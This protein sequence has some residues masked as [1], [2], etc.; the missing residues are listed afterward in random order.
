MMNKTT[1]F[2]MMNK[3]TRR[4]T[5]FSPGATWQLRLW[6]GFLWLVSV[7]LWGQ[8]L[9]KDGDW[10]YLENTKPNDALKMD[11]TIDG[12]SIDPEHNCRLAIWKQGSVVIPHSS[13]IQ[14][15]TVF[16]QQ[17]TTGKSQQITTQ[18]YFTNQG[19]RL[20][21]PSMLH[22][23]YLDNKIR[24]LKLQKGYMMTV[25]TEGDGMGYSR[26]FVAD[27]ADLVLDTL[28]QLLDSKISYIRVLPW[29]YVSKKGWAGSKWTSVPEGLKY[30][31][32][33]SDATNST[34]YYNWSTT[35][36]WTTNPNRK[37]KS[38]NQEFVPE[39]WGTGSI[40]SPLYSLD[41]VTHLMGYNEPDHG[42]Q[43][44]VS[45][46]DAIAEWP[47][48]MQTGLRL[49]SP[50]TTDFN[51][52]YSFMREAKS[53][54]YRVDYVVVHAYWGGLSGAEWYQ[55]LKEVHDA[56]GRP[57]W[58]KEWNNGANWTKEGWPSGTA[59]QQAKQLR[60]LQQILTVMDTCSFIERYSIYNWVEDKRAV[61]L[62]TG[63]LTPAG[64]Y[65]R[66]NNPDY[67]Y[68]HDQQF[69]PTYTVRTA[70]VLSFDQIKDGVALIS[71]TDECAEMIESYRLETSSDG[72]TFT[73][74]ANLAS[75]TASA[76][77]Q[78]EQMTSSQIYIRVTSVPVSGN[79]QNSNVL[80]LSVLAN[81][82][83]S[84]VQCHRMEVQQQ[85]SPVLWNRPF[86]ET[87]VIIASPTTYRNK[88]PLAQRLRDV[89]GAS[90]SLA[91]RTWKYQQSPTLAYN[92]T[93]D[94][95][96]V[97]SGRSDW[98]GIDVE[99]GRCLSVTSAMQ[100]VSFTRPFAEVPVVIPTQ[101]SDHQISASSVRALNITTEGFDV[102]LQYE[103][104]TR[105]DTL[106]EEVCWIAATPGVG[107]VD[108]M[109]VAVGRS[110][111]P[112]EDN[113]LGGTPVAYGQQFSSLPYYYAAMQTEIDTIT[114]NLR[115]K[116]RGLECATL[117]K[118][119]E[120]SVA[121]ERVKGEQVGYIAIGNQVV[122]SIPFLPQTPR[123]TDLYDLSGRPV[124]QG[125]RDKIVVRGDGKKI[126]K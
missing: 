2:G 87:P 105:N 66:D 51:W 99:A 59:E 29:Q 8:N 24:S 77:V 68:R 3:T 86:A 124:R 74:I 91:L 103:G 114:S 4:Q 92:D 60:D 27:T 55:K 39:V 73:E 41:D 25:A 104:M 113:L 97:K 118:D 12:E 101:V 67:F 44:N 16:S 38:Y 102:H 72:T 54:N 90:M 88:M 10:L 100:H 50:A 79:P 120:K 46:P 110:N 9:H 15:L 33:Q 119:R 45:V 42:E 53:R 58:I 5:I 48:L 11:I 6:C 122:T 106:P 117:I 40:S 23:L 95:M 98:Q 31:E 63:K 14:P 82:P 49:G 52:L 85:W 76:K 84:A 69:T 83:E 112:V 26:V 71:W 89:D 65:Y 13:D 121:H 64:E 61:M 107:K 80:S 108:G 7:S 116:S 96:A 20:A 123:S 93:L 19:P 37:G 126:I 111:V 115:I 28:P 1:I 75:G 22:P 21:D 81:Q 109:S 47:L 30:V 36:E 32:E 78:L 94:L 57:I 18:L 70:P 56:T 43:S 35:T 34:W 125:V 17:Y 62:S